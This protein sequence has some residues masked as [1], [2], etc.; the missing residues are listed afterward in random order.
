MLQDKGLYFQLG[1]QTVSCL[2]C[3]HQ[4][5]GLPS[6]LFSR[7]RQFFTR[8]KVIRGVKLSTR[9]CVAL[10]LSMSGSILLLPYTPLSCVQEQLVPCSV[11]LWGFLLRIKLLSD[12]SLVHGFSVWN[13]TFLPP[14]PLCSRSFY[15]LHFSMGLLPA[16]K[17][18]VIFGFSK[19][20]RWCMSL[21]RSS[22]CWVY[23]VSSQSLENLFQ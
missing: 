14:T 13:I 16:L 7:Y 19:A 12:L 20:C 21:G 8:V 2:K 5:W 18:Q 11:W 23:L 3:A 9:P 1:Q 4:L 17:F 22:P 10:L 6:C 15:V